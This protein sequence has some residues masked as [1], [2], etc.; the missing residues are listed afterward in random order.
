MCERKWVY[1]EIKEAIRDFLE[2]KGNAHAACT[3]SWNTNKMKVELRR[4][5]TA[6]KAYMENLESS[7]AGNLTAWFKGYNKRSEGAQKTRRR[8]QEI[9]TLGAGFNEIER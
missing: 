6:P 4:K 5:F 1:T 7:H 2:F 9:F 8:Q 3:I